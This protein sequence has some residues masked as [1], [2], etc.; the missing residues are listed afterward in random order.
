MVMQAVYFS[1]DQQDNTIINFFFGESGQCLVIGYYNIIQ[2]GSRSGGYYLTKGSPAIGIAAVDV[3][4]SGI[5][6]H[7]IP[8]VYSQLPRA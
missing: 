8:V 4:I 5:S 7:I 2:T 1:S 6:K 3:D